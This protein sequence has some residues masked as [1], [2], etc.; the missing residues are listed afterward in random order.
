MISAQPLSMRVFG[1]PGRWLA[2]GWRKD[3]YVIA[4][5]CSTVF[6]PAA[7]IKGSAG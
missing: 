3:D 2:C 4:D 6:V 5:R 7:C 1:E